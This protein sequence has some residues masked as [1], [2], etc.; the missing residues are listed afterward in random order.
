MDGEIRRSREGYIGGLVDVLVVVAVVATVAQTVEGIVD[1]RE[2]RDSVSEYFTKTK[3][4]T[5]P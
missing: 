3:G 4:I 5:K 2:N 1:G